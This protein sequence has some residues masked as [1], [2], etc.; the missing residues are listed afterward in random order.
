MPKANQHLQKA[1]GDS[2]MTRAEEKTLIEVCQFPLDK[3]V[4]NRAIKPFWPHHH[5]HRYIVSEFKYIYPQA[6]E[7]KMGHPS[8]YIDVS[9]FL[10]RKNIFFA[11]YFFFYIYHG[12]RLFIA[13]IVSQM[14]SSFSNY[15]CYW[16]SQSNI[17]NRCSLC[18]IVCLHWICFNFSAEINVYLLL[19]VLWSDRYNAVY[20]NIYV[21]YTERRRRRHSNV[22]KE[23][24]MLTLAHRIQIAHETVFFR[25][26]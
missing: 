17:S 9:L 13:D 5:H 3:C 12:R 1:I 15:A 2:M 22:V 8:I 14:P 7:N 10:I 18:A 4:F 16:A 11:A 20:S 19:C 24:H 23:T 26:S 6:P 25:A 21:R